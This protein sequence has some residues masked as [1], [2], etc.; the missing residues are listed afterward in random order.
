[1][2]NLPAINKRYIYLLIL[3]IAGSILFWAVKDLFFFD[4]DIFVTESSSEFMAKIWQRTLVGKLS[5][6][7][8]YFIWGK[9]PFG[10]H[11]TNFILHLI[12]AVLAL[13]LLKELL[14]LLSNQI[15]GFHAK[16]IPYIFFILFLITPVH[17]EPL[18][19]ILA[20][21]C[22]VVSFFLLLSLLKHCFTNSI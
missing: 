13:L 16:L 4:E 22:S 15:N 19:Y 18:C 2:K 17:S 3:F 12:N 8:D 5:Y 20:R 9:N 21:G 6:R 14:K 11:F 10:Y 1:M 7:W